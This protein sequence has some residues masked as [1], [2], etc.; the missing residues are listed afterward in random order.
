MLNLLSFQASILSSSS[1]NARFALSARAALD[2]KMLSA[3]KIIFEYGANAVRY[4]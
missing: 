3:L 4:Y 2:F 1:R